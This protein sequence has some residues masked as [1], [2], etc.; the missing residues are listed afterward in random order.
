MRHTNYSVCVKVEILFGHPNR[1]R[2][3]WICDITLLWI[4]SILWLAS[5]YEWYLS[6]KFKLRFV[7]FDDSLCKLFA[8]LT[9]FMD[10]L[11]GL[12]HIALQSSVSLQLTNLCLYLE[13]NWE[14]IPVV[15]CLQF[16]QCMFQSIHTHHLLKL[17]KHC[18]K[19]L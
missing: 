12:L 14:R 13:L 9:S 15:Y 6:F 8:F 18:Y 3:L 16:M 17:F 4:S 11:S 10:V 7:I 2:D 5:T 19:P 1:S